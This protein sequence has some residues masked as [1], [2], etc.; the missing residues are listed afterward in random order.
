M[1]PAM[2]ATSLSVVIPTLNAGA[3]LAPCLAALDAAKTGGFLLET[4][5]V[6]GGSTDDTIAVA[7]ASG[8]RVIAAPAGRGQQLA[9]GGGAAT[10]DWLLFLH[11]DTQLAA[12]WERAAADFMAMPQNAERAAVFRFALR[13]DDSAARRLERIVAWRCR[14]L[15]LPYGDQGLLIERGF[16][17]RLG[18]FKAVP[19]MEDVDIVRRIGRR[20]LTMLEA[21]AWTSAARYRRG[22]YLRRSARNLTCLS[23]YF[24]G[25]PPAAIARIYR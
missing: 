19:L 11:A 5:V 10:G 17:H 13:D 4:I 14:V 3:V 15:A 18:G 20:R 21:K 25:V 23:L 22:G 12:G 8:A 24:L 1:I 9:E 7:A 6:D 16:Y 2:S